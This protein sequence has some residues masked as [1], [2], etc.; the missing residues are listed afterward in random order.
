M[1]PNSAVS[2]RSLFI[3]IIAFVVNF[4][5][6]GSAEPPEGAR[7]PSSSWRIE[8]PSPPATWTIEECTIGDFVSVRPN[9]GSFQPVGMANP[10]TSHI[11]PLAAQAR[12]LRS[13]GHRVKRDSGVLERPP[14][15]VGAVH[16]T[17][18]D[19]RS[20]ENVGTGWARGGE[21]PGRLAAATV[22]RADP[23]I[24]LPT[25]AFRSPSP[26]LLC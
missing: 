20:Q 23:T 5:S 17:A 7:R 26:R 3:S 11:E 13:R 8:L 15:P 4:R 25:C 1:N 19:A 24:R 16:V 12:P 14:V 18:H 9:R 10:V 21:P 6:S 2:S 22:S